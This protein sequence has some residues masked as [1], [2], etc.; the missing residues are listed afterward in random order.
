VIWHPPVCPSQLALMTASPGD[1]AVTI[2]ESDTVAI[3][4]R[5]D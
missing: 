1:T 3:V 2:P 4:G 5:S